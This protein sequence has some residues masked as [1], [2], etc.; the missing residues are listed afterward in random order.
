MD[1]YKP[2][3]TVKQKIFFVKNFMMSFDVTNDIP[4]QRRRKKTI[5]SLQMFEK[6]RKGQISF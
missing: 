3:D 4:K 1:E 2:K 5:F 6:K